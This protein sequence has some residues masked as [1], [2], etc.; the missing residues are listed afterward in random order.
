MSI[1]ETPTEFPDNELHGNERVAPKVIMEKLNV[2]EKPLPTVKSINKSKKRMTKSKGPANKKNGKTT[3]A[4]QGRK[5]EDH[6]VEKVEEATKEKSNEDCE[7]EQEIFM[8]DHQDEPDDEVKLHKITFDDVK[9]MLGRASVNDK[10]LRT[11]C[12]A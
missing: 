4:K 5:A 9:G 8:E 3:K 7:D 10:T 12:N 11:Y 6:E 2:P 1:S